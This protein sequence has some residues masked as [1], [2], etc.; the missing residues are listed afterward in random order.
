M[1]AGSPLEISFGLNEAGLLDLSA[2][3]LVHGGDVKAK[4]ETM[5]AIT[6]KDVKDAKDRM[7]ESIIL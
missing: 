1:P 4:F 2:K 6:H 7:D 3:E 5:D